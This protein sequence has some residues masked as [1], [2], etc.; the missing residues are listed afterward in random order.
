MSLVERV[1]A[2]PTLIIAVVVAVIALILCAWI[3]IGFNKSP[4]APASVVAKTA[5]V[6]IPAPSTE[7]VASEVIAS[8][9]LLDTP[10]TVATSASSPLPTDPALAAEELD[11]LHDEN[12]R[13]VDRKAQLAKQ[14]D[15]SNKILALKEQQIKELEQNSL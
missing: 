6:S 13:L 5:P 1:L 9:A 3:V 2:R 7:S 4:E 12:S 15:T 11:R 14:L 8:T 10:P